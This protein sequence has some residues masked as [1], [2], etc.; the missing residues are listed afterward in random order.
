MSTRV[1]PG[2]SLRLDWIAACA[3]PRPRFS[4]AFAL[5]TTELPVSSTPSR[6]MS[7]ANVSEIGPSLTFMSA[8]HAESL[9]VSV[10]CAPG[11]HGHHSSHVH[12]QVPGRLLGRRHLEAVLELHAAAFAETRADVALK[13]EMIWAAIATATSS[14]VREPIFRPIG[15]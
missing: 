7:V 3:P 2:T 6:V 10:S 11:M 4:R 1:P 13:T 8:F 9:T 15:A 5:R 14:G 12:E